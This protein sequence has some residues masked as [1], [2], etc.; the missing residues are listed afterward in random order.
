VKEEVLLDGG[1]V[2]RVERVRQTVT[3]RREEETVS[4][5]E[6]EDNLLDR[7]ESRFIRRTIRAEVIEET[8]NESS[9]S[10]A[11]GVLAE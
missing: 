10:W 1:A 2:G 5:F 4:T 6:S 7:V 3:E 8:A 9:T 11:D